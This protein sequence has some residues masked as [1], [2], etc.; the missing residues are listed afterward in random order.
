[1]SQ[2]PQFIIAKVHFYIYA[3]F[4]ETLGHSHS[5]CVFNTE[6]SESNYWQ[7]QIARKITQYI[8]EGYAVV[9]VVE[10]DTAKTIQRLSS[11]GIDIEDYVESGALTLVNNDV[12]YSPS[13]A[14]SILIE[15][16]YKLFSSIEKRSRNKF[17]GF[18]AMGMPASS[19][20]DSELNE[21]R[22]VDYESAVSE[23]YDG[24][25]EALCCYAAQSIEKLP[26]RHIVAL[27]N[28][29]QH[30]AHRDGKLKVWDSARGVSTIKKGLNEAL[31]R[32]MYELVFAMLI[33]DFGMNAEAIIMHPHQFENKLRILFGTS[34]AE[35]VL[36]KIKAE[37]K[38][39]ILF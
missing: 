23:K 5:I 39:D 33:R 19:F 38:K 14:G 20:F 22:L 24:S 17:R 1:M 26:L 6:P 12:F 3:S 31:G 13:V 7:P 37:F 29:H 8:S 30:T 4:L 18:V 35:I 28:A 27:L 9:Y 34:A 16:W 2:F 25:I 11:M 15:Q 36:G 21:Q 32:G 10:Q